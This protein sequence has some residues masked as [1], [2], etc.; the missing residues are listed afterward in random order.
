M[1][2]RRTTL[3]TVAGWAGV[4]LAAACGGPAA[5]QQGAGQGQPASGASGASS[6]T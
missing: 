4:I 6:R 5:P 1:L 2:S 3:G